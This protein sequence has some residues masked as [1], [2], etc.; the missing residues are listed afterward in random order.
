MRD[1]TVRTDMLPKKFLEYNDD[2]SMKFRIW[3]Q[4][5]TKIQDAQKAGLAP[6]DLDST[7]IEINFGVKNFEVFN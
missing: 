5:K 4:V 3:Q 1:F 6:G 7:I 2:V